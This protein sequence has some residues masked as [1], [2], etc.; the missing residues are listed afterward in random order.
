MGAVS[1]GRDGDDE[2]GDFS[3]FAPWPTNWQAS[4][5]PVRPSLFWRQQRHRPGNCNRAALS[6]DQSSMMPRRTAIVTAW[7]R[8]LTSSFAKMFFR[9]ALIV[10]SESSSA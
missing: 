8:A 10:S 4:I 6:A 3:D 1:I 7:V 2:H 9:W 5:L